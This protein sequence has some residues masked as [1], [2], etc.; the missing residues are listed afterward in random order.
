Q[1]DIGYWLSRPQPNWRQ[2]AAQLAKRLPQRAGQVDVDLAPRLLA[3]AFTDR[4]AQRRGQ[5][6]RYLLA[7]G[8]GAA[9]N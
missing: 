7:N 8:M 2:R 1:M 5:D 9:M 6:G 3:P 4:I